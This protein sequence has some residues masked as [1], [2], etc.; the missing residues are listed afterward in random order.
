MSLFLF[1]LQGHVIMPINVH[2]GNEDQSYVYIHVLGSWSW[3]DF[4]K[5][6]YDA[7]RLI[8]SVKH[9]VCIITH[10][11]DSQAQLISSNAFVQWQKSLKDTPDNLQTVI[12]VPGRP[13]IQMFIDM[14]YRV[15]GQFITFKFRMAATLEDARE[16][17]DDIQEQR[18]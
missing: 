17:I 15:L 5:S 12:L 3:E 9:P 8:N 6:I 14:A 18:V 13:I 16:I 1:T 11:A 10:L 4:H 7:N 2:W